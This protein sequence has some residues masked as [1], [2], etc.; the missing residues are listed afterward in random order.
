L[1]AF[2]TARAALVGSDIPTSLIEGGA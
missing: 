1:A 2:F